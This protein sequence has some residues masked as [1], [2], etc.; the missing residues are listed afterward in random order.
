MDLPLIDLHIHMGASVA[1][2]V[3]WSIAHQ[4]GLRLPVRD[5]WE[6]LDLIT[7]SENKV[8]SVEDYLGILHKWTE[9]I[10]SSP[11]A[12]E[13]CTYE[14]ISKEYRGA[15]VTSIELRFNPMKRNLGG[16]RDL[17]HIIHA[18][19][20]GMDQAVLE[21]GCRAGLIFCM[22]REFSYEL[23]EIIVDKAIRYHERGVVG[24]DLA[25]PETDPIER[26]PVA[27]E[28]YASLLDRARA[29]GLGVTIHTGE[30]EQTGPEGV[31]AAVRRLRPQRIGHGIQA[32][33]SPETMKILREE[34]VVLEI[35]PSS[36]VWCRTIDG[37]E[38]VR[39]TLQRFVEA[40]V[41]FTINTD[42]TYLLRTDLMNE[43]RLLHEHGILR[44]EQMNECV[45]RARAASFLA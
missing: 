34:G 22:A 11:A 16:E 24:I 2:H 29:A 14:I 9:K 7:V 27:L 13:R 40:S 37:F 45:R 12:I 3:M 33:R 10:Q 23:N 21:Y 44:P 41:P 18:A 36:N 42:G 30:T 5:Y 35:C 6:F 39:E 17:D 38:G 15:N 26:D 20:R 8:H 32:A 31:A 43:F 1:P 25:G 28:R 19:L 4:Q